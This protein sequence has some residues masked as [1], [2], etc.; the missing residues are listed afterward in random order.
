VIGVEIS[1]VR[2]DEDANDEHCGGK[3]EKKD[4]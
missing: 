4:N 2:E 1:D 3:E